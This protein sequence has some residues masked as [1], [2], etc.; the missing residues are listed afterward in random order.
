MKD[1]LVWIT[2][3]IFF[4]AGDMITTY[5]GLSLPFIGEAGPIAAPLYASYGFVS[6][7]T[8]KAVFTGCMYLLWR[9]IDS[10]SRIG[11]PLGLALV[12][13]VVTLWNGYQ[14]A[15]ILML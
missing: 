1:K 10:L 3:L 9:Q 8:L 5:I 15:L 4:V 2:A 7:I 14:I 6:L 11:I 13:F 12:G